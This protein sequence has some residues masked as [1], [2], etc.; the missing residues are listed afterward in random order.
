MRGVDER[1]KFGKRWKSLTI[2]AGIV[3]V[4][5]VLR[6]HRI[7]EASFWFDER[8][9][10]M[11]ST[12]HFGEWMN[13]PENVVIETPPDLFGV[14]NQN[15]LLEAW[16]SPD[17]H[18]PLYAVV[19]RFW[20][21]VFGEK[22]AVVR[23]LSVALSLAGILVLFDLGRI[24]VDERTATWACA[25]M[26][27]AQA[28]IDMAQEARGY[29]LWYL[30]MLA[31]CDAAARLVVLGAGWRRAAL[32]AA[33]LLGM[34]LTHFLALGSAAAVLI[35]CG[36]YLRGPALR[37]AAVCVGVGVLLL[38]LTGGVLMAQALHTSNNTN[39]LHEKGAG[40]IG[41]TFY[42]AALMPAYFL[43]EPAE[44][45]KPVAAATA[46][47]FALPWI[48]GG[49]TAKLCGLWMVCSVGLVM[50][51]DLALGTEALT[52]P[53][54]VLVAA[55]AFY[56]L[57]CTLPLRSPL[58]EMLPIA[59]I[60]GC[61]LALPDQYDKTWKGD[62]RELGGDVARVARAGDCVVFA[63]PEEK[64]LADPHK[65]FDAVSYYDRPIPCAVVL[66]NHGASEELMARLREFK[67]VWVVYPE[68]DVRLGEYLPGMK[69]K[70][71]ARKRM[72]AGEVWKADW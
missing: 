17:S 56:L 10:V 41:A 39:W 69:F 31:A 5:A 43:T 70:E 49:R 26:A 47:V 44:T 38:I 27:V 15:S 20:R 65:L 11:S 22:D 66:M 29:A 12:G 23:A 61:V 58:R 60:L 1:T 24:L 64:F 4:G 40:H 59:A 50:G 36:I 68:Q 57:I 33:C 19:L 25:I 42:R 53:R 21:E 28:Q 37:Q 71:V 9:S 52:Y 3:L 30:L 2:L 62:W 63:S 55:P 51:L 7:G 13:L 46:V 48:L 45:I 6:V 18:P 72:L 32:L 16:K 8:A 54:F 34:M 67:N 35:W 14:G